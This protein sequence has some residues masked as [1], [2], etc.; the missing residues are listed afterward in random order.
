MG[1]THVSER[2]IKAPRPAIVVPFALRVLQLRQI[3]YK[4]QTFWL[5]CKS[6]VAAG[7]MFSCRFAISRATRKEKSSRKGE[8]ANWA[9]LDA[10][11]LVRLTWVLR[12][13]VQKTELSSGTTGRFAFVCG[14]S[15]A[16]HIGSAT[17]RQSSVAT[18]TNGQ[19][20]IAKAIAIWMEP[21][22]DRGRAVCFS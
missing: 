21:G 18:K 1:D 17:K 8:V 10:N 13:F 19:K 3:W 16:V 9:I 12:M 11:E 7:S 6:F 4:C 20:T 2:E 14:V 22:A 5:P 15:S